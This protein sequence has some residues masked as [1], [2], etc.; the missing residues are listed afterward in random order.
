MRRLQMLLF[1]PYALFG[2]DATQDL[3]QAPRQGELAGVK[4]AIS[5][6]VDVESKTRYGQTPLY[7]A[8]MNGHADVVKLLLENGAQV[9]ATDA[10]YKSSLIGFA[11]SR[12]HVG[13]VK[14][15]CWPRARRTTRTSKSP[16]GC[17]MRNSWR[18]RSRL[19]SRRRRRWMRRSSAHSRIPPSLASS[20]KRARIRPRRAS[21]WTRRSSKATRAPIAP[22]H[23]RL[24]SA[25]DI[26]TAS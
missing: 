15:L 4:T 18:R 23:C 19:A 8:A 25:S 17:A 1:A 11:A 24:P 14:M 6:K 12:K 16:W 22:R 20:R 5:A 7:L 10:F 13:A 21:R 9:D 3:L 2:F 26:R